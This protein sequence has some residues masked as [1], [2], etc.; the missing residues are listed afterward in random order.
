MQERTM[1]KYSLTALTRPPESSSRVCLAYLLWNVSWM[2]PAASSSLPVSVT[3]AS[4]NST[5]S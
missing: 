5:I 2:S 3:P 4:Q 1:Y